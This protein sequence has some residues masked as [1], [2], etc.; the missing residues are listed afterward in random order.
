MRSMSTANIMIILTFLLHL[1]GHKALTTKLSA[2]G[3]ITILLDDIVPMDKS[4]ALC[5]GSSLI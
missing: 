2:F 3:G 4:E 1:L 5:S